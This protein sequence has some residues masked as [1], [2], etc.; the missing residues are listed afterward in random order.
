MNS[1]NPERSEIKRSPDTIVD[2]EI[3]YENLS[4]IGDHPGSSDGFLKTIR[5]ALHIGHPSSPTSGLEKRPKFNIPA[6]VNEFRR[7]THFKELD[8]DLVVLE[9]PVGLNRV[10]PDGRVESYLDKMAAERERGRNESVSYGVGNIG[11]NKFV[12]II[13]NWEFM[14]ATSGVVAGEKTMRAIE[15]AGTGA[16]LI[17]VCPSGGQRQ[18]EGVAALREML[19]TTFVLNEFKQE[20]SQ[21]LI[22]I[23]PG[24]TWGGVM[25]SVVPMADLVI[26]MAGSDAGF[27]GPGVIEAFEGQRPPAGSQ[28]VENIAATNRKIQVI[29]HPDELMEYLDRTL[30]IISQAGNPPAKPK[31]FREI[32]GIYFNHPYP[33][34]FIPW[35]P[36]RVLRNHPRNKIALPFQ[37]LEP[38]TVWEQH[39]LLRSDPRRPDTSYILQHAFDGFIPLFSGRIE[40]DQSGKHLKYPAIIAA[41]AYIDD[42]RLPK[43]LTKMIIGNQPSYLQL[44]GGEIM[45]EHASPTAWDYRYQLQMIETAR[46]WEYQITTFVDTFGARP[47]LEDDLAAQY[48]AITKCLQEQATFPFFTSGYLIGIGGSGGHLATDFTADYAAMLSGAQEFVAEPRSATAILYKEPSTEDTI[49][50]AE[51]MRPTATSLLSLGLI[52]KII[53]EPKGG[54]QN[55]PLETVRLIREDVILTELEFGHLTPE[56]VL[57]RR[58]HRIKS[59][60]PIPIGHLDGKPLKPSKSRFRQWLHI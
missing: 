16:P 5:S 44:P 51:G 25:A 15:R 33:P 55:Y 49:R 48:E 17:I 34:D 42:P 23:L 40:T 13:F 41:L 57:A 20:S 59:A 29:L 53:W 39:Q 47:K 2:G 54:A 3:D 12:G 19:R 1:A 60:R 31:N 10:L 37:P 38:T 27:A 58:E 26:G 43:R 24:N 30:K 11:G 35:R 6:F 46:R 36:K 7:A 52:D 8:E 9:D 14:A 22:C 45:K 28:T 56:E 4:L 32:S 50:T 18:Q 21:P